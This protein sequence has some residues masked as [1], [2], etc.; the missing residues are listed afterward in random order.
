MIRVKLFLAS[1]CIFSTVAHAD[2]DQAL[3]DKINPAWQRLDELSQPYLTAN[4]QGTVYELAFAAAA[5]QICPGFE[6]DRDKFVAAF[7]DFADQAHQRMS[8]DAHRER[9]RELLV[10]YGTAV[11]L[12][13]AEGL[14]TEDRFCSAAQAAKESSDDNYWK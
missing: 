13:S 6:V 9:E 12:L 2:A 14:L 7:K 5:A 4:Q 1:L 8:A 3:L 10:F 11:G